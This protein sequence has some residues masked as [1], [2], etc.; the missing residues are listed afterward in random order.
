MQLEKAAKMTFIQKM[1]MSNVEEIYTWRQSIKKLVLVK[2]K[3]V[4]TLMVQYFNLDHI[5]TI[6]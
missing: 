3:L 2:S 6:I 1:C 5:N 4:N